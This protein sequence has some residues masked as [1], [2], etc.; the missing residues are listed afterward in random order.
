MNQPGGLDSDLQPGSN[1]GGAVTDHDS[2][3][4]IVV[5][6]GSR[7][8]ESN[9]LLLRSVSA[10]ES[11]SSYRIVEPAHMELAQ[12]DIRVAFRRCVE[13]GADRIVVFPWFLAPGRHW[14]QD[15]P[16]LVAAAAV[17]FPQIPWLVTAPFGLHPGMLA[18]VSDRIGSCLA[19]AAR[20]SPSRQ[21]ASA[22]RDTSLPACEFCDVSARCRFRTA[23]EDT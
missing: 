7:R 19:Q 17:E 1:A 10:F 23:L 3:G 9:D 18:V 4:V 8:R 6:H 21:P 5:D 22:W 15:I 13:R 11:S 2:T 12:P 14:D 20:F 16:Q